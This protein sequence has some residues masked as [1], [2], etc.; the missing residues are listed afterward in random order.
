MKGNTAKIALVAL[1]V[2]AVGLFFAFDLGRYLT[3]AE[4]K[5]RQAAFRNSTPATSSSPSAP[6]SSFT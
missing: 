3:L 5:A 2:V 1:I 4:L 6:T